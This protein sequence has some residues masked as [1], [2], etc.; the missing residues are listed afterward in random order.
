M[1]KKLDFMNVPIDLSKYALENKKINEVRLYLYLKSKSDGYIYAKDDRIEAAAKDLDICGKTLKKH[2]N[3]LLREGWLIMNEAK[4]GIR[5][6]SYK[7][8]DKKIS[9]EYARGS[10]MVKTD[11][12]NYK[13]FAIASVIQFQI[14]GLQWRNHKAGYVKWYPELSE[15]PPYP[16]LPINYLAKAMRIPKSTVARYMRQA[17]KKKY[18]K[19]KKMFLNLQ[20]ADVHLGKIKKYGYNNPDCIRRKKSIIHYQ[21]PNRIETNMLIRRKRSLVGICR[22]RVNMEKNDTLECGTFSTAANQQSK[23]V[24]TEYYQIRK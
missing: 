1:T 6:I 17:K 12:C 19:T 24:N 5:I 7:N 18:I 23:R 9:F 15:V 2:L 8:L 3:W 20:I 13:Y 4:S 16:L 14:R 21:L 22:K 11:I 10:I